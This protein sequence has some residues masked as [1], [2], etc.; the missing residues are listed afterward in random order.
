MID[1]NKGR[2]S[3]GTPFLIIY[4]ELLFNSLYFFAGVG[5]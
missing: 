2:A 4:A 1:K 5:L 3:H